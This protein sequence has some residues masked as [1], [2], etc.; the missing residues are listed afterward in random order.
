MQK[1]VRNRF[2]PPNAPLG[3]VWFM[4]RF[5]DEMV[6]HRVHARPL[7]VPERLDSVVTLNVLDVMLAGALAGLS[8]TCSA[9]HYPLLSDLHQ[10][11]AGAIHFQRHIKRIFPLVGILMAA[12]LMVAGWVCWAEG[13]ATSTFSLALVL[14]IWVVT[15]LFAA[16][17]HQLL[18]EERATPQDISRLLR[19]HHVRTGCWTLRCG[20]VGI[21]SLA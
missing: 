16:P 2:H 20:L 12:E 5:F 19:A 14:L 17:V 1:D 3:D 11:G 18:V 13:S 6:S 4:V 21:G 10:D 9:V 15:G 8:W 7:G